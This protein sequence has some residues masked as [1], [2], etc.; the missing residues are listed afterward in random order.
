VADVDAFLEPA[1][2]GARETLLVRESGDGAV[3][4]ALR[5][6]AFIGEERASLDALCQIIEGVSHFVYLTERVR[7]GRESTQ[8][9]LELQ[10]EVDKYVVLAASVPVLDAGSS[11]KIRE[12]LYEQVHFTS[13]QE[14]DLGERYRV[15]ND[16]AHRFV[17]KL[18]RRF[19]EAGRLHAMR[20][21]LRLFHESGLEDKL[22]RARAA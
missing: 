16:Q 19:V 11:A 2:E 1:E 14:T 21:E 13:A 3:E 5:V 20:D 22:R 15:A 12:K 6:P 18:E 4:M 8:L 7:A 9:E 10:A 17:H